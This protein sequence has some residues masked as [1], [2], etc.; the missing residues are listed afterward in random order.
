MPVSSNV[1]KWKRATMLLVAMSLGGL[2][3]LLV[4]NSHSAKSAASTPPT[5][6][7]N[8]IDPVAF[9][10]FAMFIPSE[11][12]IGFPLSLASRTVYDAPKGAPTEQGVNN[13][14]LDYGKCSPEPGSID[15]GCSAPLSVQISAACIRNFSLYAKYPLHDGTI[16]IRYKP[17]KIGNAQAID[18]EEE[19]G[20][21]RLE[22]YTG[23]VTILIWDQA[24]DG[25]RF[26]IANSLVAAN[27][28]AKTVAPNGILP[29]PDPGAMEGKLTCLPSETGDRGGY[30]NVP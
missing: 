21:H 22:I 8:Q 6:L 4:G 15:S 3:A 20:H 25:A 23:R 17:I 26:E 1:K 16:A 11:K 18:V 30:V 12:T 5:V 2:A 14:N 7:V 28:L 13:V 24:N 9:T 29:P 27:D 10:A 19:S